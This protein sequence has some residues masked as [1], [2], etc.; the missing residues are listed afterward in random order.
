MET[1]L[2]L[3]DLIGRP[4]KGKRGRPRREAATPDRI[5]TTVD[6]I[7][8]FLEVEEIPRRQ[9]VGVLRAALLSLDGSRMGRR[10]S[11]IT[12]ADAPDEWVQASV[13]RRY[14]AVS[15]TT[16]MAWRKMWTHGV[17]YRSREGRRWIWYN[18]S[19]VVSWVRQRNSAPPPRR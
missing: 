17:E 15:R 14:C 6:Q 3:G 7:L 19:A 18:P 16:L 8:E 4:A 13:L 11:P 10:S 2:D 5:K 1:A 9:R 12:Q